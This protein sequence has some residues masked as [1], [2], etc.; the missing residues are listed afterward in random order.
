[1]SYF[2]RSIIYLCTRSIT[3]AL[4]LFGVLDL[5]LL[6]QLYQQIQK[7]V[8]HDFFPLSVLQHL[9][10]GLYKKVE[11]RFRDQRHAQQVQHGRRKHAE[12]HED[13]GSLFDDHVPVLAKLGV[14]VVQT[15]AVV[16]ERYGGYS[17]RGV[18]ASVVN[19]VFFC[20]LSF[21]CD[22]LADRSLTSMTSLFFKSLQTML[23]SSSLISLSSG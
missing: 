3:R 5:P 23:P 16:A 12:S 6:D 9:G 4:R 8:S 13:G 2:D 10:E 7:V 14:R 15:V 20:I 19:Q 21:E 11:N 22:Y 1:M 18:P 17:V